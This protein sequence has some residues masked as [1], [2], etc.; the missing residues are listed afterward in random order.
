VN[1]EL[2]VI[3]RAHSDAEVEHLERLG[4]VDV[5]MGEREIAAK[6]LAIS[7]G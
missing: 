2:R 6:M 3:A 5:V 7:I 1:P 4:A